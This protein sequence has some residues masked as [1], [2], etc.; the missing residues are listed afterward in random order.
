[1][2]EDWHKTFWKSIW[3]WVNWQ[4]CNLFQ[5]CICYC[6]KCY[7]LFLLYP[8]IFFMCGDL[9]IDRVNGLVGANWWTQLQEMMHKLEQ[10]LNEHSCSNCLLGRLNLKTFYCIKIQQQE[11]SL[12]HLEMPLL[13]SKTSTWIWTLILGQDRWTTVLTTTTCIPNCTAGCSVAQVDCRSRSI[14]FM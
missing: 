2:K 10:R 7:W 11:T 5:L 1:M 13:I 9:H 4:D 14:G 8:I 12:R 6:H 3:S